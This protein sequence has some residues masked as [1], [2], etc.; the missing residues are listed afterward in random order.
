[1]RNYWSLFPLVIICVLLALIYAV[2]TLIRPQ[3]TANVL[4]VFR[5]VG[6]DENRAPLTERQQRSRRLGAIGVL[7]AMVALI[8][9]NISLNREANGCYLVA[10]AW[11]ADDS[12]TYDDPCLEQL[13]GEI[14]DA[15]GKWYEKDPQPVPMYQVVKGKKPK[16]LRWIYGRPT[17]EADVLF[18]VPYKC[19]YEVKVKEE[20][21]KVV[22]LYDMTAPC[23]TDSK[24]RLLATELEKPLGD[25]KVVTVGDK[26]LKQIDPEM[27]SWGAVLKALVTG[28]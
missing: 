19:G 27:P 23:P 6:H 24:I 20:P 25:R 8:G 7:I 13:I 3:L 16:Y 10:K 5:P 22:V 15:D 18:G 12:K 11:G 4:A 1:M 9:F 21:D 14:E 28:G 2:P 17:Y 26:P